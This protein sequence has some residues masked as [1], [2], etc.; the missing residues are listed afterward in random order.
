MIFLASVRYCC[1]PA[2]VL[3]YVYFGL[4][5]TSV[6]NWSSVPLK[7]TFAL[8]PSISLRIRAT[9]KRPVAWIWSGVS[10]VVV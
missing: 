9:S 7:P 5:R 3:G 6:R 4:V 1:L 8:I 10:G 2:G